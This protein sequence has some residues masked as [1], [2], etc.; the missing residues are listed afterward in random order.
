MRRKQLYSCFVGGH[1][2]L[3]N[4]SSSLWQ[5]RGHQWGSLHYEIVSIN[6]LNKRAYVIII[7]MKYKCM[8][9][10]SQVISIYTNKKQNTTSVISKQIDFASSQ[11]SPYAPKGYYSPYGVLFSLPWKLHPNVFFSKFLKSPKSAFL[12]S[13][14]SNVLWLEP[15]NFTK[16]FFFWQANITS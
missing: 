13:V 8:C 1:K 6:G 15:H 12:N 2:K 16:Q 9:W 3:L 14:I 11:D 5:K 7:K 10:I 4:A